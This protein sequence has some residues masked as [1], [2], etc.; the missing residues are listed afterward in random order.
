MAVKK[1]E[2][3]LVGNGSGSNGKRYRYKESPEGVTAPEFQKIIG[4]YSDKLK[5]AVP[6]KE[7]TGELEGIQ[8]MN[9]YGDYYGDMNCVRCPVRGYCLKY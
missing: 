2:L 5:R 7:C 9:C 1:K 3:K 6:L 4:D 8:V